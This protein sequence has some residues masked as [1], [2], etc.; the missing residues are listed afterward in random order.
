ML[1]LEDFV[2]IFDKLLLETGDH[3]DTVFADEEDGPGLS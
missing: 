3:F 2:C 1:E